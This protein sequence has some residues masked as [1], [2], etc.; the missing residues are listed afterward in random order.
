MMQSLLP[1]SGILQ[2]CSVKTEQTPVSLLHSW[3]AIHALSLQQLHLSHW[4]ASAKVQQQRT[5]KPSF[6]AHHDGF[7]F[8][9]PHN[10]SRAFA[11]TEAFVQMNGFCSWGAVCMFAS[12]TATWMASSSFLVPPGRL[13]WLQIHPQTLQRNTSQGFLGVRL[14][15]DPSTILLCLWPWWTR[16]LVNN[17]KLPDMLG[18]KPYCPTA[19]TG[20]HPTPFL[21]WSQGQQPTIKGVWRN[22]GQAVEKASYSRPEKVEAGAQSH[23][24][25]P[26]SQTEPLRKPALHWRLP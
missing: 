7:T 13:H 26:L 2:I 11:V 10:F 9:F 24:I 14:Q 15:T 17:Q 23:L 12:P 3:N 19:P 20:T 5:T 1:V 21:H 8:I 6:L 4:T 25:G 16:A 22:T 18:W